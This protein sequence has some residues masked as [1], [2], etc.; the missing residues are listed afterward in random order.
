MNLTL[1]P[2]QV[3]F[4]GATDGGGSLS[5]GP[6]PGGGGPA[7]L[8]A[9]AAYVDATLPQLVGLSNAVQVELLP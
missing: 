5:F 1:L 8:F 2:T 7:T 4:L 9:Q 3:I 6:V